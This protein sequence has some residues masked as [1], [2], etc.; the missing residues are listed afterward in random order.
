MDLQFK[1]AIILAVPEFATH[2]DEEVIDSVLAG[3]SDLGVDSL[4]D[5]KVGY[6]GKG[7]DDKLFVL[8]SAFD[9]DSPIAGPRRAFWSSC[10][11]WFQHQWTSLARWPRQRR[12]LDSS[13]GG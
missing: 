1:A 8:L 12:C 6:G 3:L 9:T 4:E 7:G 10:H 2:E 13:G 5:L 11:K